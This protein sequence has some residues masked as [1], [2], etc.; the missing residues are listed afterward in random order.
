MKICTA[1]LTALAA[2]ALIA[3][4][5]AL[6]AHAGDPCRMS[7]SDLKGAKTAADQRF[8]TLRLGYY[9]DGVNQSNTPNYVQGL[10]RLA[11]QHNRAAQAEL[12]DHYYSGLLVDGRSIESVIA[13]NPAEMMPPASIVIAIDKKLSKYWAGESI[14]PRASTQ[15]N[16]TA[17]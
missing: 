9:C 15:A 8:H 6:P 12:A 1:N 16:K 2:V 5:S 4:A 13:S 14:K 7:R 11:K 3:L 10:Q 17:N